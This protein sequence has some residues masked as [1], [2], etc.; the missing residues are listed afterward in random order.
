MAPVVLLN[1]YNYSEIYPQKFLSREKPPH[2]ST[3]CPSKTSGRREVGAGELVAVQPL[4]LH[5]SGQDLRALSAWA[6][7]DGSRNGRW[8]GEPTICIQ[9]DRVK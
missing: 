2:A 9:K 5:R 6:G 3:F 1:L 7:P 4:P 8:S